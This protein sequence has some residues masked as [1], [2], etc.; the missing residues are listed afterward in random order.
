[1]ERATLSDRT[2]GNEDDEL[3]DEEIGEPIVYDDCTEVEGSLEARPPTPRSQLAG[4]DDRS[5]AYLPSYQPVHPI[6]WEHVQQPQLH[7]EPPTSPVSLGAADQDESSSESDPDELAEE[8]ESPE[9]ELIDLPGEEVLVTPEAKREAELLM[10][11][12]RTGPSAGTRQGAKRSLE[13]VEITPAVS[14]TRPAPVVRV[15]TRP[16]RA[17]TVSPIINTIDLPDEP[18]PKKRR[19][20]PKKK[21]I[22]S[23]PTETLIDRESA[24]V[25]DSIPVNA[26]PGRRR[27]LPPKKR[28]ATA[29]IDEASASASSTPLEAADALDVL[30]RTVDSNGPNDVDQPRKECVR[31][32]KAG[33]RQGIDCVSGQTFKH[34]LF[35]SIEASPNRC[36]YLDDIY[37]GVGEIWPYYATLEGHERSSFQNSIRHNLSIHP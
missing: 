4:D 3:K 19:A 27:K 14:Q 25:D 33:N 15:S 23:G 32:N 16:K 29:S 7:V 21:Q 31:L 2:G 17:C 24:A 30:A 5:F 34:M 18:V 8:E 26:A 6:S 11:F 28:Q 36:L 20:S 37:S 1:M 22:V 10:S 9:R 13:Q 12:A 35:K